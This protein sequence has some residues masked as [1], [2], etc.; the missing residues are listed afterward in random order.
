MK[1]SLTTLT[2]LRYR[3]LDVKPENILIT[4]DGIAKICDLGLSEVACAKPRLPDGREN[5]AQN[6]VDPTLQ[7]L[8]GMFVC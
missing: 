8:Q 3:H 5:V 2:Y 1:L 4:E 7:E 6:Y